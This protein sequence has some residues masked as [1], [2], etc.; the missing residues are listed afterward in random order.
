[1]REKRLYNVVQKLLSGKDFPKKGKCLTSF[2]TL[3]NFFLCELNNYV[4]RKHGG[5]GK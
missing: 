3:Q 1:M 2:V 5:L 4:L